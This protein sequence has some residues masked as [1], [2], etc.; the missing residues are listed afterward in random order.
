MVARILGKISIEESADIRN[1]NGTEA[2]FNTFIEMGKLA[3]ESEF[4][5]AKEIAGL[6]ALQ[7]AG[8]KTPKVY[9]EF[10]SDKVIVMDKVED[11]IP[12]AEFIKIAGEK[13]RK[14]LSSEYM[15]SLIKMLRHG[16]IHG[17]P[18]SGNV[19]VDS[20]KKLHWIDPSP[21]ATFSVFELIPITR[22]MWGLKKGNKDLVITSLS[23]ISAKKPDKQKLKQIKAECRSLGS[24]ELAQKLAENNLLPNPKYISLTRALIEAIGTL[25]EIA[26]EKRNPLTMMGLVL[27]GSLKSLF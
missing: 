11:S 25:V 15:A 23:K 6:R 5:F 8:L 17:D 7:K 1:K 27:K 19:L 20:A 2:I 18:H 22:L 12:L 26:P 10:S 24:L 13:D 21:L 3:F 9:D 4:D 14:K 16:V